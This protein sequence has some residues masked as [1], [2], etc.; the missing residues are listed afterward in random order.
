MTE[1]GTLPIHTER[2]LLRPLRADDAEMLAAY[3]NDDDVARYQDWEL[4]Y[5]PEMAEQF[6]ASQRDVD[7]GIPGEWLQMGI[8][9]DGRLVGDVAVGWNGSGRRASI[10]Y[11]LASDAQGRGLATEAVEAV[12][13]RLLA[14]GVQRIDATADPANVPSMRLLERLGFEYEGIMTGAALVRGEWLDD[15]MY[16]L[17][18]QRRA[19]WLAR[20][21]SRAERVELVELTFENAPRYRRLKTH[22]TQESLVA[23]TLYSYEDALFPDTDDKGGATLPW[24]R[25][26]EADGEPAGFVMT[27]E[28][29]DTNSDPYL[30]RLLIDRRHQHR[31]IGSRVIEALVD[32]LRTEGQSELY[33]SWVPGP[34][35]PAAF[36]AGLGFVETGE[37]DDGEVVAVLRF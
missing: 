23:P 28:V 6:I 16:G 11:S 3:R 25:G 18:P 13:D 15:V 31:G 33:V 27:A 36:Y 14:D 37:I 8:E 22:H 17:T 7:W 30:W 2:L 4:P 24:F 29:T 12:V 1:T 5:T 9:F 10:G 32:R 19:D 21:R 35:S 34:G 26:I 20:N